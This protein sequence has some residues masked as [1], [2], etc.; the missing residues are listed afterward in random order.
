MDPGLKNDHNDTNRVRTPKNDRRVVSNAMK[1][2]NEDEYDKF[3]ISLETYKAAK[4]RRSLNPTEELLRELLN[5]SLLMNK[6]NSTLD[7]VKKDQTVNQEIE[8][9][10]RSDKVDMLP[11]HLDF[12]FLIKNKIVNL[13]QR[14]NIINSF[15]KNKKNK[16]VVFEILELIRQQE[17][18]KRKNMEK[19]IKNHGKEN[20]R[21][22]KLNLNRP[23]RPSEIAKE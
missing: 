22:D 23:R 15:E 1:L 19:K 17:E 6:D 12:E 14:D 21:L 4:N 9:L 3:E 7:D 18:L 10:I 2:E 8:A 13:I 20:G 16:D 11:K 5:F